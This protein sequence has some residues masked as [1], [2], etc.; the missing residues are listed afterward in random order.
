MRDDVAMA[1]VSLRVA[2]PGDVGA[3]ALL[4]SLESG[5]GAAEPA[6]A[7]QMA[8]WLAGEGG[9]R[10]IWL[11]AVG[12]LPVGMVSLLEYRRMP[13][14]GG[15]ASRWGYVGNMFVREEHRDRG[16]G[17]ALLEALVAVADERAYVRLVLAP[18]ARATPLYLRA[19]FMMPGSGGDA[20]TLLVRPGR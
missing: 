6:F 20:V 19:G 10:T 7:R 3:L 17:A 14:P 18:S 11:A 16:I 4:R 2:G 13:R 1:G 5:A 8:H 12:D 9:R 15:S